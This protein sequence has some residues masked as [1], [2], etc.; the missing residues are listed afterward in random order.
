MPDTD[1]IEKPT[2]TESELIEEELRV[3]GG[4]EP[5]DKKAAL[6]RYWD[7]PPIKELLQKITDRDVLIELAC[8][9]AEHVLPI[10]EKE[11]PDDDRPRKA[12]EAARACIGKEEGE[13]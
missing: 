12:I 1:I 11:F 9:F 3:L 5:A 7:D 6:Y 2:L 10:F 4:M 13:E 8:R